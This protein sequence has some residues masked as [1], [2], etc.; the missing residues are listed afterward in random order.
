MELIKTK[1]GSAFL[2]DRDRGKGTWWRSTYTYLIP[3][4]YRTLLILGGLHTSIF[5]ANKTKLTNADKKI[6]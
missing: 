6:Q 5:S 3:L 1:K 4:R 2:S